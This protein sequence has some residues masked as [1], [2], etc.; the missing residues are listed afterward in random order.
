MHRLC[1]FT[2]VF[3]ALV[4][5]D[6][7]HDEEHQDEQSNGAHQSNK[8]ALGGDVYLPAGDSWTQKGGGVSLMGDPTSNADF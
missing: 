5:L 8:P 6:K 7:A 4:S 3:A 1:R 2:W